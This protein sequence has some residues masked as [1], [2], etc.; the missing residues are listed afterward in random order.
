MNTKR[1]VLDLGRPDAIA[2]AAAVGGSARP[3]LRRVLGIGTLVAKEI[4]KLGEPVAVSVS[5]VGSSEAIDYLSGLLEKYGVNCRV[6]DVAD[7]S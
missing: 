2:A 3:S 4:S 5:V 7:E 1:L 6:E